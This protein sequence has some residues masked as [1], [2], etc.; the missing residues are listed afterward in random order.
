MDF[1]LQESSVW[2]STG[3]KGL[4]VQAGSFDM[5]DYLNPQRLTILMWDQAFLLRHDLGGSFEDYDRVLEE[6]LERGYNTVRLDPL[7]QWVDLAKPELELHWNDPD[8]PYM[9]WA[10]DRDVTG[11]VGLWL[12]EFM[13]TLSQKD[14]Y[15][16]L[17]SWWQR[18][19]G[20]ELLKPYP[21]SNVEAAEQWA[22]YLEK[23][24]KRFGFD[25]L[26]YVDIH[27]EWPYFIKGYRERGAEIT[28]YNW[29]HDM[30]KYM[31][32]QI[33]F[34]AEDTNAA[35]KM[36]QREFPEL[37]FTASI[38]GDPRWL[39]VPLDFD[40]LDVHFYID[41]D[42]RWCNRTGFR[43]ISRKL[44]KDDSW[45]REFSERC[46]KAHMACAPMLRARQRDKLMAFADWA[47]QKGM[48][49][50]TSE[51]WACWFYIDHEDLDW[52]WLLDWAEKTVDDAIDARMWGWT[53]HNYCQPQFSNWS[54][55]KWHQKLT[56]KF[57]KSAKAEQTAR[58]DRG[59]RRIT[60]INPVTGRKN[61]DL[62]QS[63][64]TV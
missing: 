42:T 51:S 39:D 20:P 34:L 30:S 41:S 44:M 9:P 1:P 43:D 32:E 4:P 13:E 24:R 2:S 33:A 63:S 25:R 28:G 47:Q 52:G 36:L 49:L 7:L 27:N 58:T 29:G 45:F 14:L 35:M 10:W 50:T 16:T 21:K 17:S 60:E 46:T 57:L 6:T 53:P 55:A 19:N 48:P 56:G 11:R 12:I 54:D 38:H 26:V 22:Q 62:L 64:K 31:P 5:R 3:K 8:L 15:Y 40:C 37:L 18:P 61:K 59:V 23:W